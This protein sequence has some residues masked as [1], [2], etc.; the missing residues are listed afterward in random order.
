MLREFA[1]RG[2]TV[3]LSSHLLH[4][5]EAVAD[6][7]VIIGNGQVVAQGTAQ[8]LLGAH[9]TFVRALDPQALLDTLHHAGLQWQDG[10]DGRLRVDAEPEA[11][12]L[13]TAATGV[14]LLELRPADNGGL[15][16]LF[17]QLTSV[18]SHTQEAAA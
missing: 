11:I 6:K 9:G 2:G 10:G 5:V 1:S 7:L 16:Q 13:A 4:E 12:G 15:E 8:E 18:P 17:L 3:L 14:A